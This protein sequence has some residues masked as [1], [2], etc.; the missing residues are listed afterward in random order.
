MN[1]QVIR[2]CAI[3]D[4]FTYLNDHLDETLF[5]LKKGYLTRILD[6][7]PDLPL[8]LNNIG[9]NG[10]TFQDW[11]SQPIPEADVYTILLGTNDWHQLYPLGSE[12]ELKHRTEGTILGNLGILLDH[13]R[14][15]APNA[16]IIGGNPVERA[17]FVYLLDPE[18]NA[19]GSYAPEQS[20]E[21]L[22]DV[23]AAIRKAYAE[24][25]VVPVD[26]WGRSGFTQDRLIRFKHVRTD[27]GYAD[28]PYPEYVGIPF[29]PLH[30]EHPYPPE[31]A[32]LTYD[33]LHPSD[34]GAGILAGLFAEA[35]RSVLANN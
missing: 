8:E 30:D 34:E 7:L 16:P 9:I 15:V 17:D 22:R 11:V 3:G 31:C 6:K 13:I 23:S 33:G 1:Q 25:G 20:G 2:W 27:A 19:Q 4:S 18:N 21:W 5:R 14:A 29:D 10:S 12:T 28:L 26:L 35:F 24:E 32:A